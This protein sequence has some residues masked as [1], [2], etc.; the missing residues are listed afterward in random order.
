MNGEADNSRFV[1]MHANMHFSSLDAMLV[2]IWHA[3][4]YKHNR[5]EFYM[6]VQVMHVWI[7]TSRC[8]Y[9]CMQ[10]FAALVTL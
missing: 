4:I 3:C 5:Y 8:M 7:A 2:H 10:M 6:T 1:S 9:A